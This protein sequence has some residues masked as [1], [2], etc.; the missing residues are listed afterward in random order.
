[1]TCTLTYVKLCKEIAHVERASGSMCDH[2]ETSDIQAKMK[3]LTEP[4]VKLFSRSSAS[5]ICIHSTD[6]VQ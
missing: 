4:Q 1:M 6:F 2:K 5:K 3:G